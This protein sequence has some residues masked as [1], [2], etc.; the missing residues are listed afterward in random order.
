MEYLILISLSFFGQIF[1]KAKLYAIIDRDL[2]QMF[3]FPTQPLNVS[4]ISLHTL[5]FHIIKLGYLN[6]NHILSFH[7]VSL[8]VSR[9]TLLVFWWKWQIDFTLSLIS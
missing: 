1:N 2:S 9:V 7:F 5:C 4:N 6:P 8:F 3:Y